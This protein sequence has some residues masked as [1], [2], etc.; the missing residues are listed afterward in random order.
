V[1]RLAF[2]DPAA[3][4][5]GEAD[6]ALQAAVD[7]VISGRPCPAP[8]R[9]GGTDWQRAVWAAAAQIPAGRTR[10]YAELARQ[11]GRGPGAARAVGVALGQNPVLVLIPCHRVVGEDGGLR[12]YAGGLEAKAALLQAE[13]AVPQ[14]G[15]PLSRPPAPAR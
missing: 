9:P 11:L 3:G 13:G 5:A 15:L 10:S 14:L 7:A 6:P 4:P 12:G 8:L 1:E 2:C